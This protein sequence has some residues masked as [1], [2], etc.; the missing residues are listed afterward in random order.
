MLLTQKF[1]N[2]LTPASAPRKYLLYVSSQDALI[3]FLDC[4]L[5]KGPM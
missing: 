4:I 5:E 1:P 2:V 3:S